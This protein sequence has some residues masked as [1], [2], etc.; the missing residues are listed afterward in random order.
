[1]SSPNSL[2]HV[3]WYGPEILSLALL[4]IQ[5]IDLIEHKPYYD[6]REKKRLQLARI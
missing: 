5:S 4:S 1:M 6:S 3:V 2:V